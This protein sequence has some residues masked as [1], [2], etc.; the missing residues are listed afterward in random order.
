MTIADI[1]TAFPLRFYVLHIPKV[2]ELLTSR[3]HTESDIVVAA[4]T[5]L[6]EKAMQWTNEEADRFIVLMMPM[7]YFCESVYQNLDEFEKAISNIR[8][9]ANAAQVGQ[10]YAIFKMGW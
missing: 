10:A 9:D 2:A 3:F 6:I 1:N 5:A 8:P 4:K 7:L